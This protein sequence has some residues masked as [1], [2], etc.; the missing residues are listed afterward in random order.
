MVAV[1]VL[2]CEILKVII[3]VEDRRLGVYSIP[4]INL[5]ILFLLEVCPMSMIIMLC[6]TVKFKYSGIGIEVVLMLV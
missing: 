5:I 6:P 2:W 1:T 4:F 3:F